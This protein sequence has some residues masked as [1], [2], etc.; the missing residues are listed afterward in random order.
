MITNIVDQ[1]WK[2]V[3]IEGGTCLMRLKGIVKKT[4]N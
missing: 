4:K 2:T 3:F 1:F